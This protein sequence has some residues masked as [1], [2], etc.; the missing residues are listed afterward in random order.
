LQEQAKLGTD[1]KALREEPWLYHEDAFLWV[2][3]WKLSSTRVWGEGGTPFAIPYRE[4]LSYCLFH[5]IDDYHERMELEYVIR[6]LDNAWMQEVA[7]AKT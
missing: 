2:S 4:L 1:V 3:F 7:K 5:G 6:E